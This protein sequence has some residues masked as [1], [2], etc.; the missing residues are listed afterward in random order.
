MKSVRTRWRLSMPTRRW[1]PLRAPKPCATTHKAVR[2]VLARRQAGAAGPGGGGRPQHRRGARPRR[3]AGG[4]ASDGRYADLPR[5]RRPSTPR[6]CRR[7][8]PAATPV[9]PHPVPT[10]PPTTPRRETAE[11]TATRIAGLP[12]DGGRPGP[13]PH[14]VGTYLRAR[15]AGP[16]GAR[17]GPAG[18]PG[19]AGAPD[20][21]EEPGG[22]PRA[23][24]RQWRQRKPETAPWAISARHMGRPRGRA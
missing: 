11:P 1:G 5:N 6:P 9:K 16:G 19:G 13:G 12:G 7:P 2:R 14:R 10:Q 22:T 18:A 20:P 23:P 15:E 8:R 21:R 3:P 24:D 4:G 17:T